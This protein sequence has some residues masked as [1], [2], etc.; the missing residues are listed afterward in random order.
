MIEMHRL[1][2]SKTVH[3]VVA[4]IITPFG[5]P[6]ESRPP[7]RTP[8]DRLAVYKEQRFRKLERK[9]TNKFKALAEATDPE[10]LKEMGISLEELEEKMKET[11]EER[12]ERKEAGKGRRGTP[13]W[14]ASKRALKQAA[15]EAN[16]AAADKVHKEILGIKEEAVV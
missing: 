9:S 12:R 1:R 7:I 3:H 13:R 2:V 8:D 5:E 10:V 16:D 15:A 14:T 6:V 11:S 4:S